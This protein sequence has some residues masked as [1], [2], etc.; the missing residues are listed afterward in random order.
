MRNPEITNMQSSQERADPQE[1]MH[2]SKVGYQYRS[3]E[4]G[5]HLNKLKNNDYDAVVLGSG[6]PANEGAN[7][8]LFTKNNEKMKVNK[9][10]S[11]SQI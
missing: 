2:P 3:N 11:I 8:G 10:R 4:V 6:S 7:L 5:K 1:F 9:Y